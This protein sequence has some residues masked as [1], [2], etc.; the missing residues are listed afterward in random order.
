MLK[1]VIVEMYSRRTGQAYHAAAAARR[2]KEQPLDV[3]AR[4][5][6]SI[7]RGTESTQTRP[8]QT[9]PSTHET[10]SAKVEQFAQQIIEYIKKNPKARQEMI[11]VL[12]NI[13]RSKTSGSLT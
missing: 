10:Q 12:V 4:Y 7:R 8:V 3:K 6:Q 9:Q 11:K 13:Q 1:Q 5:Q 2:K